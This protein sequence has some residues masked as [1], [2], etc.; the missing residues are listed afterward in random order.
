MSVG[1]WY[2]TIRSKV[3][4][5]SEGVSGWYG[6][7]QGTRGPT[8]NAEPNVKLGEMASILTSCSKFIA[9]EANGYEGLNMWHESSA[10][11]SSSQ[12]YI[13]TY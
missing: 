1:S 7:Q 5:G 3:A 2:A 13:C 4:I 10:D 12:I 11:S 8:T 9:S 6:K